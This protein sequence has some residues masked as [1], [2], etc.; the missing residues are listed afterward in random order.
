MSNNTSNNNFDT[1]RRWTESEKQFLIE[2]SENYSITQLAAMFN[3]SKRN[4]STTIY[5]MGLKARPPANKWY[6]EDLEFLKNNYKDMT[7]QQIGEALKR[8]EGAIHAKLMRLGLAKNFCVDRKTKSKAHTTLL[9]KYN[10]YRHNAIR[11]KKVF[12][13]SFDQFCLLVQDDCH[14][15]GMTPTESN[16]YKSR[17]DVKKHTIEDSKVLTNGIDR[18]DNKIG[19]EIENCLSC[20][21]ACNLAKGTY[22]YEDFIARCR[23]IVERHGK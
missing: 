19:Y 7:Y 21:T 12:N 17:R 3:R 8:S 20:C 6:K 15:C 16:I 10:A 23:R 18:K 22:T 4:I 13:I 11:D 14:Y 2:N 5:L 1:R 9:G